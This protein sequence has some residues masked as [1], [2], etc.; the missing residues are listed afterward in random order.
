MILGNVVLICVLTAYCWKHGGGIAQLVKRWLLTAATVNGQGCGFDPRLATDF[1][2]PTPSAPNWVI[3]G[4]GCI[5]MSIGLC[6]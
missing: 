2:Q 1:L 4:K 3:K 5:G 6:T